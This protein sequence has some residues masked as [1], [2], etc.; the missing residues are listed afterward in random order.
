MS[1]QV[2]ICILRV[3]YT[4]ITITRGGFKGGERTERIRES[5]DYKVLNCKLE[6]NVA[7]KLEEVCQK[8]SLSKTAVTER[9]IQMYY[10]H[11]KKTGKV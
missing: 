10:E 11:Y 8:T 4:I 1:A 3:Y 9:S 2:N 7:D 5:K 6:K